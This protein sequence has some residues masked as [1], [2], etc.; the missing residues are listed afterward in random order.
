MAIYGDKLP[1][2]GD[3]PITYLAASFN[4]VTNS[5]KFYWFLAI[6]Q[7]L[8]ETDEPV[9]PLDPLLARM[10]AQVWYPT[11]YFYLSFGKQDRLSQIALALKH[12][13]SIPITAT[14]SE[15]MA[16]V[17]DCLKNQ[18]RQNKETQKEIKSLAAYVPY[19]FL[20]PFFLA[21]LRGEAD[22]KI[23]NRIIE[24]AHHSFT[25]TDAPVLYR[26]VTAEGDSP[27]IELHPHWIAYLRQHL[28]IL[29]GFVYWHL[30]NYLQ[31]NNPNVP[32][33]AAKLFEPQQRELSQGRNFWR[34]ALRDLGEIRCIYSG[35]LMSRVE[36]LDHFLPWSFVTHDL[37]WN[38]IP[39]PRNINAAKS[40]HLP[41]L[42]N[43]FDPFAQLQYDAF[44]VVAKSTK[45]RLLEDYV[46]L[47]KKQ[48]IAEVV[49]LPA[50]IFKSVLHDTI[51]PQMQIARN[52]GFASDWSYRGS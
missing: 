26:F 11:N 32:N 49:A 8:K 25:Q 43:Y 3:I 51:A 22:W 18:N 33:I 24:L 13:Y 47:F 12:A 7:H 4:A 37:L 19:R 5:Y 28:P 52:M 27:A 50:P 35:E 1:V 36:S 42:S 38:L 10:V 31:K 2:A 16:A 39:T 17:F 40:D 9:I 30:L 48:T 46:L 15:V 23:N 44:H 6:L 21:E 34:Q 20:R 41:Q 14:T 29:L 45:G